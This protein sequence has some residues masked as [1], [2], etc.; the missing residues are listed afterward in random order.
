MS[1]DDPAWL[2][3]GV[4]EG[5]EFNPDGSATTDTSVCVSTGSD[6]PGSSCGRC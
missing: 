2:K 4:A 5:S 3:A 6:C 1:D